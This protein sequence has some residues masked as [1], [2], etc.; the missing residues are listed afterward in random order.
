VSQFDVVTDICGPDWI[1][2][3]KIVEPPKPT[4]EWC[5][6]GH[7]DVAFQAFNAPSPFNRLMQRLL[8]GVHWREIK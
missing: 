1:I 2:H 8:L 4:W 3:A 7:W 6:D 5:L